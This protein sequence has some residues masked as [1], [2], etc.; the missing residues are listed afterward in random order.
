MMGLALLGI[1]RRLSVARA[2]AGLTIDPGLDPGRPGSSSGGDSLN[3]SCWARRTSRRG[4]RHE[5]VNSRCR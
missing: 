1:Q 5:P 4:V 2:H 3:T